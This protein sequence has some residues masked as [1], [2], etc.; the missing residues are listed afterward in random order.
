MILDAAEALF[1]ERGV[2][3][4][5]TVEVASAAKVSVGRLYYWFPDKDTITNAVMK[6]SEQRLRTFLA[7]IIVDD[8][9][10]PTPDL[11]DFVVPRLGQFFREHPGSLAVLMRGPVDVV[12]H[13]RSMCE[14]MESL[15]GGI[16]TARVPDIPDAERD[17]VAATITRLVIGSIADVVRADAEQ[18][19]VILAELRYL[20]AAYMH[21]RYPGHLDPVWANP[22]EPIRPS[23]RPVRFARPPRK[24]FPALTDVT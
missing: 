4:T 14:Y 13:G 1:H 6:R 16:L 21:C 24:I 23:R 11:L 3:E 5:S 15:A 17:L 12:D 18:G 9:D 7:Q 2:A 20:L 19:D 22:D 10:L 8:P